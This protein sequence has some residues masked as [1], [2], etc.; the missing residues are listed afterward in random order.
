MLVEPI[1]GVGGFITPPQASFASVA[2]VVRRHGGVFIAD[3]VQTGFGRTGCMR[4]IEHYGV[5][6]DMVKMV[7]G[8]ANGLELRR[9]RRCG[10]RR[11]ADPPR[12][13][14]GRGRV[15]RRQLRMRLLR[16]S[17]IGADDTSAGTRFPATSMLKPPSAGLGALAV[18][19]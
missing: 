8:I 5:E 1:Q 10:G 7:G 16:G 9:G 6:P 19:T 4:G 13:G 17:Y 15:A 2:Q 12:A 11:G 3:A 18:S 14:S